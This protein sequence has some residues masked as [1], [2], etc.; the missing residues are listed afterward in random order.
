MFLPV[1]AIALGTGG[2]LVTS[3]TY[4]AKAGEAD[5]LRDAL[6]A[7]SRE[8]NAVGEK[9]AE[10]S[11]QAAERDGENAVLEGRIREQQAELMRARER[12][13][14]IS[15]EIE[16]TR[17]TRE[18]LISELLEKE[19]ATGKR[20]QE[21]SARAQECESRLRTATLSRGEPG[22]SG[23]DGGEGNAAAEESLR[24]ERDILLGRIERIGEERLQ[25]ERRRDARFTELAEAFSGISSRITAERLGPAM[26]VVVPDGV[27]SRK[28][29]PPLTEAGRRVIEEMGKTA[30]EFPATAVI[31][32]AGESTLT[33]EISSLLAN[34]HSFPPDRILVAAGNGN[35]HTEL[36][37]IVP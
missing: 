28:G 4:E 5:A 24:R 20:I 11:K 27:L 14:A 17:I 22:P 16:G 37:L 9:Y 8:R 30:S 21:L 13:D 29:Q 26:R 35:R 10:L 31:I 2:C 25:E 12:L 18:E 1:L 32:A 3:S 19:K 7:A 15:T 6:A 34:G 33:A 36:V 23:P